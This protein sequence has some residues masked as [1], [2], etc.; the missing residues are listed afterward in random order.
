MILFFLCDL[1]FCRE[2]HGLVGDYLSLNQVANKDP[3]CSFSLAGPN[4]F[5]FGLGLALPKASPW[6]EDVNKAV[7]KNQESGTIQNIEERWF[8]RKSCDLKPFTELG[9]IHFSGLFMAVLIVLA[10]CVF[11]VLVEFTIVILMIKFGKR[12]GAFG[13]F[14]KRF[15]FNVTKGEEDQLNMQY[16]FLLSRPRAASFDVVSCADTA[17]T[18]QE[19]GFH[20]DAHFKSHDQGFYSDTHNTPSEQGLHSNKQSKRQQKL[21]REGN[22]QPKPRVLENGEMANGKSALKDYRCMNGYHNNKTKSGGEN[23]FVVTRL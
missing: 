14:I 23:G 1:C 22:V 8:N 9:I 4:F 3:N 5:N 7:L 6:L 10:F 12:L 19:L 15:A 16:S 11:A 18:V 20:N 21:N 2:I 17:G 13:K